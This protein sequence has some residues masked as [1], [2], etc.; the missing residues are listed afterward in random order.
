[1]STN[2]KKGFTLIELLVVISIIALLSSI[3]LAS[4]NSARG[5]ARTAAQQ[6]AID[7]TKKALQLYW[8]DNG[9]FPNDVQDL[10]D[11]GYISAVDEVVMTYT[12]LNSLEEDCD[13]DDICES[14]SI[15]PK[16]LGGGG[17][18]TP[19]VD[20]CGTSGDATDPDCWSGIVSNKAWGP[21]TLITGAN[22]PT[23]GKDNTFN[24]AVRGS[25][26]E[27]AYY[28]ANLTE[29]GVPAGTWYLPAD[30]ELLAGWVQ[31]GSVT[32]PSP[33]YWSSTENFRWSED[34]ARSMHKS[35]YDENYEMVESY[36]LDPYLVRC[37][38]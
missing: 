36:K 8:T 3:V 32:F 12:P 24:L 30:N 37:L 35:L 26:Y 20:A 2:N 21:A 19:V 27:A 29:G 1:M 6:V 7:Q 23:D 4:L 38:R 34:T 33:P 16:I 25:S 31:L 28:C 11:E 9:S 18:S 15:T 10:V 17:G 14:Y 13:E 5:K 22:S